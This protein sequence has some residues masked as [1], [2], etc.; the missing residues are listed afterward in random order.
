[1]T[2]EFTIPTAKEAIK[3]TEDTVM[4]LCDYTEKMIALAINRAAKSG[5]NSTT[6][7]IPDNILEYISDKLNELGYLVTTLIQT[8]DSTAHKVSICW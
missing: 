6:V 2:T 1:M 8:N 5:V 3:L 4:E 7:T